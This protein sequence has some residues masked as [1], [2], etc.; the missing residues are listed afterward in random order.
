MHIHRLQLTYECQVQDIFHES[1]LWM[2]Q[3]ATSST[4]LVLELFTTSKLI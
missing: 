4:E 3:S 2:K 1:Q